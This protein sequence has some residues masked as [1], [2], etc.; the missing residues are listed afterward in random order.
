[1]AQLWWQLGPIQAGP[2]PS[3]AIRTSG[4]TTPD[5]RVRT[6][7]DLRG[8]SPRSLAVWGSGVRVPSAP[9]VK[10]QVSN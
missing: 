7:A 6:L 8:R 2:S 9:L 4:G 5:L 10:P 1:M 3:T